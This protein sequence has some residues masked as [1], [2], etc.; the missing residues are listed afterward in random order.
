MG[1]TNREVSGLYFYGLKML[2]TFENA[3]YLLISCGRAFYECKEGLLFLMM[4]KEWYL[5]LHMEVIYECLMLDI[6][7]RL[8]LQ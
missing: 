5:Q 6:M 8:M 4:I 1:S 7:K 3:N 2:E